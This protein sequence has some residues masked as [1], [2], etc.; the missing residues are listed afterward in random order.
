MP[1]LYELDTSYDDSPS[2][3]KALS[4]RP[5]KRLYDNKTWPAKSSGALPSLKDIAGA[6]RTFGGECSGFDHAC[7]VTPPP[8]RIASQAH[9]HPPTATTPTRRASSSCPRRR[10]RR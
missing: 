6:I 3:Y 7:V 9:I 1:D 10:P 4:P 8:P 2:P 5:P